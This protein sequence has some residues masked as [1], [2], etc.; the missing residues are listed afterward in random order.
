MSAA[1]IPTTQN[2]KNVSLE[3]QIDLSL[4]K[5]N[6]SDL[7]VEFCNGEKQIMVSKMRLKIVASGALAKSIVIQALI[8]GDDTNNDVLV[9]D[10]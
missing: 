8:K 1:A 7:A 5:I 6:K 9:V 3:M 4:F 10:E 2:K